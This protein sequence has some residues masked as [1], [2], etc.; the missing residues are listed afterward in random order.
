MSAINSEGTGTGATDSA[1]PKI[2]T[3]EISPMGKFSIDEKKTLTFTVK[4]TDNSI[5]NVAFSLASNA[6]SGAKISSNTGLFTWSPTDSQGGRTYTFDIK[7]D[8]GSM[9]DNQSITITVND[10]NTEPP[11]PPKD[12]TEPPEPPKTDEPKDLGLASF[13]DETKDPQSYVDRYNNE[14]TYKKVV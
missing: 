5:K 9:T 4:I 6:P 8:N 13:V 3:L 2:A 1:T 12:T 14:E 7:A 11:E 10:V